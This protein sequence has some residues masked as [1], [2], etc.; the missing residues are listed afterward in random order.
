M[1]ARLRRWLRCLK[2]SLK[3]NV[4]RALSLVI[5]M[6]PRPIFAFLA[7]FI[8]T[9]L[10]VIDKRVKACVVIPGK[11]N[12]FI[13]MFGKVFAVPGPQEVM[14]FIMPRPFEKW[15]TLNDNDIIIEGGSALGEDTV[16][17]AEIVKRGIII[18]VEPNPFNL[19]FLRHN[20]RYYNNIIIVNAALWNKQTILKFNISEPLSSAIATLSESRSSTTIDISTVTIDDIVATFKIGRVNVIKLNIEGAEIEALQGAKRTLRDVREILIACHHVR[21]GI[22]TYGYVSRI[23]RRYGF[24]VFLV[25]GPLA[26]YYVVAKK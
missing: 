14:Q 12:Y 24:K 13:L 26:R 3:V 7:T 10:K 5:S 20:I 8:V 4:S 21:R 2:V 22:L 15:L 11:R 19:V 1:N 18:A 17:M 16:R 9:V 23:L 25:H 6:L